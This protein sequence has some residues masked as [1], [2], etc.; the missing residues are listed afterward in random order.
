MEFDRYNPADA[1]ESILFNRNVPAG[2][3]CL[4]YAI[5]SVQFSQCHL[6]DIK[7]VNAAQPMQHSHGTSE[8]TAAENT[9]APTPALS[10]D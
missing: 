2:V 3:R 7:P 10:P 8:W 9:H 1:I 4:V 5:Q 6:V